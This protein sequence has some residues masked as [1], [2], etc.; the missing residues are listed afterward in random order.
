MEVSNDWISEVVDWLVSG[1]ALAFG[2]EVGVVVDRPFISAVEREEA[3]W[4]LD[5][6]STGDTL[7][8]VLWRGV[9]LGE[10]L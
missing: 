7:G 9:E 8:L 10:S 5:W 2:V 4:R 1:L 3:R 6:V